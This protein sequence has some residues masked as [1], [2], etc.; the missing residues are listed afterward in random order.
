MS[1][2][3][4]G[5]CQCGQVRYTLQGEPALTYACFCYECQKRTGSAFSMGMMV[6]A[7]NIKISGDMTAFQRVSEAGETNTRYSCGGCGNVIYGVGSLTP[8]LYK[9]QPGT[10]N[11]TR[12]VEPDV[13]IWA[14]RKPYWLQ[15][16]ALAPQFD[17][18]PEDPAEVIT[19]AL[20]Y[21]EARREQRET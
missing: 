5:S 16:P 11:D 18:Q 8:A 2:L 6:A 20:A 1:Q 17:E 12:D 10:L 3:G 15:L 7:D 4:E 9:L 21:R 19:A 14:K 13:Y